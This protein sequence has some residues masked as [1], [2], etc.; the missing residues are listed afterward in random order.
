MILLASILFFGK[1][2]QLR[3]Y[4]QGLL[5]AVFPQTSART[6]AFQNNPGRDSVDT[7]VEEERRK[8]ARLIT[9]AE[10]KGPR[11]QVRVE[12]PQ[13]SAQHGCKGSEYIQR[14]GG[15]SLRHLSSQFRQHLSP[16]KCESTMQ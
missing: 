14:H 1:L 3:A 9:R 11:N 13:L 8:E 4:K 12:Q 7:A 16:S 5:T 2:A 10:Q 6:A 15:T